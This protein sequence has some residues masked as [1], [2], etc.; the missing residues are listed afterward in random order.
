LGTSGTQIIP[1][2]TS[3][4]TLQLLC[5]G[6][7][8]VAQETA[9]ITVAGIP[10]E[11]L[12]PSELPFTADKT[13]INPGEPVTVSW[14]VT[15]AI[16]CQASG[17]NGWS[18][19]V[20]STDGT[21]T[22]TITG[23]TRNTTL[24]LTCLKDSSGSASGAIAITVR[25]TTPP[26]VTPGAPLPHVSLILTGTNGQAKIA[27]G[28]PAIITWGI[29]G[30]N[31]NNLMPCRASGSWSGVKGPSG[32]ETILS[33][34]AGAVYTLTCTN[35]PSGTGTPNDGTTASV[36]VTQSSPAAASEG[37]AP[38]IKGAGVGPAAD[39]LVPCGTQLIDPAAKGADYISVAEGCQFEHFIA[40]AKNVMNFLLFTI[41]VPIAAI[42]FAW[43]GWLY[44][45][46]AGNESK[47]GEAH[48]IFGYVVLG[49]CVALAA[50]LIV[51]AIVVGL[52]VG[53]Q[54]NF[55]AG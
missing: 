18:G 49:L 36:S 52:G 13:N 3:S 46:A 47:V 9:A 38:V 24:S 28:S 14:T 16:T 8:G 44:L 39:G 33:I 19:T 17:A 27:P 48:R 21:H 32:R 51:N 45:S 40:L 54:Y 6:P 31:P 10:P 15:R 25:N 12:L 29:T 7:G 5:T 41:A 26:P 50:W 2:F 35:L 42:S 4:A 37:P 11:P 20:P 34:P 23:I 43:A 30:F 1:N 55:L 53:G 22:Q